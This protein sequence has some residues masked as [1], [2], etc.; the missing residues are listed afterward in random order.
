[1][2]GKKGHKVARRPVRREDY[3]DYDEQYDKDE[4]YDGDDQYNRYDEDEDEFDDYEDEE[5]DREY[6]DDEEFDREYGDEE[7][8]DREYRDDEDEADASDEEDYGG[9][10]YGDDY[11]DVDDEMDADE[12]YRA[13]DDE[14]FDETDAWDSEAIDAALERRYDVTESWDGEQVG[15]A[16]FGNAGD[17]AADYHCDERFE[18]EDR[19]RDADRDERFEEEDRRRDADRDEYYEDEE[20]CEDEEF[21]EDEEF[22][23]E[24]DEDDEDRYEDEERYEEECYEDDELYEDEEYD[25]YEDEDDDYYSGAGCSSRSVGGS[26][27]CS[28]RSAGRS[29]GR[30][31]RKKNRKDGAAA[32]AVIIDFFRNTGVVERLAMFVALLLVAAGISM[33]VIYSDASD[34]KNEI[35]SFASVGQSMDGITVV[36]ESGLIAM[37]DAQRAKALAAESVAEAV[38]ETEAGTEEAET[39][40]EEQKEEE[41]LGE[42]KAVKVKVTYASIKNDIK[43][44]FTNTDTKKLISGVN[45]EI[46]VE[47]PDGTLV[48]YN[49]HDQDGIIYKKDMTAGKYKITPKALAA[50]YDK[51]ILETGTYTLT[52]KD[53]VEMKAVDVS[54]EVKKESQVNAAKEDTAEKIA[55]ESQLSDTVEYIESN[56]N[57]NSNNENKYEQIDIDDIEAPNLSGRATRIVKSAVYLA[58]GKTAEEGSSVSQESTEAGSTTEAPA[59]TDN[60]SGSGSSEDKSGSGSGSSTD[61]SGSSGSSSDNA[62]SGSGSSGDASTGGNS[63]GS[64]GSSSTGS[65][66]AGTSSSTGGNTASSGDAGTNGSTSG[67]TG[68]S[69][70]GTG[71]STGGNTA[72]SGD[73]G[74][75]GSTSGSTN[76]NSSASTG[77]TTD[78]TANAGSTT[79]PEPNK[80]MTVSPSSLK[81]EE[82]QDGTIS[83][84]GPSSPSYSSS[85]DG[86]ATVSDGKVHAVKA[87]TAT[88]TITAD[89]YD[90]ATVSVEVTAKPVEKSKFS[91]STSSIDLT[92]EKDKMVSGKIAVEN[93]PSDIKFAVDDAAIATVAADGTVT[94]LKAGTTTVKVTADNYEDA[95]VTVKVA[96]T[97]KLTMTLNPANIT[98]S[99]GGTGEITVTGPERVTFKSSNE[100]VVTVD[101]AGKIK[102]V[103]SGSAAIIVSAEGYEDARTEVTVESNRTLLKDRNG[104]QVYVKNGDG[105]YVEATYDDYYTKKAFYI[106]NED[107]DD[108]DTRYGWW[109][110]NG[111]TYYYDKNGNYVTGEQVIQGARYNFG[112][113][114][115]LSSSSGVMGIDVSKWNGNIDWSQVKNSGVNYVIIRCGYRGSSEGAL[116]EDPKFRSN[117]QGATKAG[118]KVGVYFFTQAVNEAEAVEEASMVISLIRG[119]SL[120]YP[121]YLDVEGSGGRGDRIDAGQRTAN[122][123]AFCG[124]IQN[125][126]YRAGVYANKTWFTSKINTG[127]LTNYKIWLAQYTSS[128]TY[129]STRYDM[130]QY[131]SKGRISGISGNVDM[132]I[133][134]N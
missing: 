57:S 42:A 17:A 50:E 8:F 127:S 26:T 20:L 129:N 7:E 47:G 111:A 31:A 83:V 88:I 133:L 69:T 4:L 39:V 103:S 73:A 91:I 41:V 79:E 43:V 2:F 126:G 68:G 117:I 132:N 44:K 6:G 55:V 112:S 121:V 35:D 101:E 97:A 59:Q 61:N 62:G 110:I 104:R 18:E 27:G 82:G 74:T 30:G 54:G 60:T 11:C 3:R 86:V 64:S 89:K 87:G 98:I 1:M 94:A 58:K 21:Y 70:A 56:Q 13:D 108:D 28:S 128:V 71:S 100:N 45:F 9:D 75:S 130:W 92:L 66:D 81:L 16:V 32:G 124:T 49:D 120:S 29:A 77:S 67:S 48:T 12:D 14:Y 37:A 122:I 72:S 96:E 106:L 23:R 24:Y 38:E 25:R 5:F 15:A 109:T 22:D 114:G 76:G 107:D 113:D 65:G 102:G 93:A 63:S 34:R 134:Y 53:T 84:Q 118:L 99:V 90:K 115:V 116:I 95:S 40:E 10:G 33:A 85:N 19:R 105:D 46:D 125:A 131:T 123:K 119:Y 36:G 78:N 52:V 80:T 51:Y